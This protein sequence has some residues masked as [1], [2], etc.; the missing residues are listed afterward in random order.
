[1]STVW[2]MSEYVG[3]D[4]YGSPFFYPKAVFATKEL[5]DQAAAAI[6]PGPWDEPAPAVDEF[7]VQGE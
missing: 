3:S 7:E 6:G 1:M 2:V 4:D 5:A